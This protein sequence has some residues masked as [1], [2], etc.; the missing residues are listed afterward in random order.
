MAID[1]FHIRIFATPHAL[2]R[3]NRKLSRATEAPQ[4]RGNHLAEGQKNH[5][6]SIN[7]GL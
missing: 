4:F 3:G 7:K 6:V 5:A 2:N 1:A